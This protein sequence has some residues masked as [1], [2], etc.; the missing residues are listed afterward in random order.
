MSGDEDEYIRIAGR[1]LKRGG[2]SL[3]IRTSVRLWAGKTHLLLVYNSGYSEEYRRFYYKDIQSIV[4][5]KNNRGRNS[6]IFFFVMTAILL[7]CL[8]TVPSYLHLPA[9]VLVSLAFMVAILLI[10][11]ALNVIDGPTC[12]TVLRTAVSSE[13][14]PPLRRS[15]HVVKAMDFL[16]PIIE[17]AQKDNIEAA[18]MSV[19]TYQS[20]PRPG[21]L[22]HSVRTSAHQT[23]TYTDY[24]GW[25][26]LV[27]FSL[28]IA[29]GFFFGIELFFNFALAKY[30]E[31]LLLLVI[32]FLA[33]FALIK[34]KGSRLEQGLRKTTCFSLSYLFL[35]YLG[36]ALFMFSYS[37]LSVVT[38]ANGNIDQKIM[39]LSMYSHLGRFAHLTERGYLLLMTFYS[40]SVGISG[41][42]RTMRSRKRAR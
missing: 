21:S 32:T 39:V 15:R 6:N 14:L 11:L 23:L 19:S 20:T 33:I 40:I 22:T 35:T 26:H 27:L 25:A 1:G 31:G 41:L 42:S 7:A 37:I 12:V 4:C 18:Q 10:F 8:L 29:A 5:T 30:I 3:L 24:N 2:A 34:Q 38:S 17:K 13:E 36:L 16:R 9:S 28:M